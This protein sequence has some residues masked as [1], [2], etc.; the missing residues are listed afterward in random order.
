MAVQIGSGRALV[1]VGPTFSSAV[2]GY[3]VSQAVLPIAAKEGPALRQQALESLPDYVF[4]GD[5]FAGRGGREWLVPA[6]ELLGAR[7][8]RVVAYAPDA[9]LEEVV[10]WLSAG[11]S[12]VWHGVDERP[13]LAVVPACTAPLSQRF[14]AYAEAQRLT[15]TL[16]FFPGLPFE[17]SAR[18]E[19][20]QLAEASLG[21]ATGVDALADA[22]SVDEVPLRLEQR[23]T[24]QLRPVSGGTR[25]RARLLVVED[26]EAVRSLVMKQLEPL[27][28]VV[29]AA[30]G[31][32]GW[33][34]ACGGEFDVAVADLAMPRLDGWGF[35]RRLRHH[36]LARETAVLVLSAQDDMRDTLEAAKA[37]ARAYLRKSG[38]S[39]ELTDAV[40][41]LLVP[42]QAVWE[43]L[44]RD[45][46]CE[47]ELPHVGPHWLVRALAELDCSGVL[48]AE[49][50]MGRYE[51]TV[52]HGKLASAV[53][54]T[55]SFRFEGRMALDALL[56]AVGHARFVP[57]PDVHAGQNAGWLF[58]TLDELLA[59]EL[60]AA[61]SRLEHAARAVDRLSVVDELA[62][63]FA[64]LA[65]KHEL[66]VLAALRS[67]PSTLDELSRQAALPVDETTPV[68]ADL[69]RRGVVTVQVEG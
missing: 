62:A 69:L 10:A 36:P 55:G 1:M 50:V 40:A 56:A 21:A 44:A 45:D 27:G 6:M 3:L 8:T 54:Q 37:G 60:K 14:L 51:L 47:V 13:D 29:G 63:L 20:G 41:K 42:R 34:M 16:T 4:L 19:Y 52:A 25:H 68:L 15:G 2:E 23:D 66:K 43:A 28:E 18:F 12:A 48:H 17:G 22:L 5:V 65:S 49:D 38:R 35:L 64:T 32:E 11:A 9:G 39:R 31:L 26:D 7:R 53:A 57:N 24:V 30:D 59:T 58:S 33:A 46:G 67:R 61:K